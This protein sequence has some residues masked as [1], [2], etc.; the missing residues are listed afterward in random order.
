MD[1]DWENV[2]AVLLSLAKD[3][4]IAF[5]KQHRGE[6]FCA[7]FMDCNSTYGDVLLHMNTP[8]LLRQRA[9][10]YKTK[11]A[12]LYPLESIESLEDKL[13]FSPG[14]AGYR[15]LNLSEKWHDEAWWNKWN[16]ISELVSNSTLQQDPSVY[17][18]G[19]SIETAFMRTCCRVLLALEREGLF[20]EFTRTPDF[21]AFCTDY[22]E[23]INQARARLEE[24][25][26]SE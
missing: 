26:K 9:E 5:S 7:F 20:L 11:Y 19:T 24:V 12:E 2:E 13:R 17:D 8:S 15:I 22:D 6:R 16:P 14:D 1:L 18:N 10:E 3:D 4:V 23:P 21:E 25:R